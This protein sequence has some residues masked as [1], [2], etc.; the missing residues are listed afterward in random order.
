MPMPPRP[1]GV[2]MATMVSGSG[3]ICEDCSGSES[4]G[5]E[6]WGFEEW[7]VSSMTRRE[8]VRMVGAAWVWGGDD[9][10]GAG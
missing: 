8:A 3:S 1:G 7:S 5:D 2:E 9:S 4:T 10:G 6:R